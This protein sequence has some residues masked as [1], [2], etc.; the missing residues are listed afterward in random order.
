MKEEKILRWD[1]LEFN[2]FLA[3]DDEKLENSEKQYTDD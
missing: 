3:G 1:F 2:V